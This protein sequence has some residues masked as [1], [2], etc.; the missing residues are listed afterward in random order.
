MA[1]AN[2]FKRREMKF[3]LNEEQYTFLRSEIEKHMTEEIGRASG[4]E[5]V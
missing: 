2:T 4:R 5:R 1:Y 3:L